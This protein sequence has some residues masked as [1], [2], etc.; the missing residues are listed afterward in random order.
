MGVDDPDT[1]QLL[2]RAAQ[3][4]RTA[5]ERLLVRHQDRLRKMIAVRMDRRLAARVD[6]S[7]V[8]QEALAEAFQRMPDY[9]RER[10]LP[11]YPWLRQIA[12]E[13]LVHVHGRHIHAGKRSVRREQSWNTLPEESAMELA[14][15]LVASGTSPS[16][17]LM[18]E[19][20]R[21]RVR[22]ALEQLNPKD[23]EV[24]VLRYMEQLNTSEVAAVLGINEGAVK[25]RHFRAIERL[26]RL[27]GGELDEDNR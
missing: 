4:D 6:P 16:R 12:W 3:G 11:F 7:D 5:I 20:M 19:E 21:R 14:E 17:Q 2:R 9:L 23:R 18:R 27:L 22:N 26:H 10:R 1:E 15:R 8:V 24:L 13:R 25:T